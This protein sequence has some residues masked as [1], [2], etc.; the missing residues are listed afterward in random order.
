[1]FGSLHCTRIFNDAGSTC[2]L[3]TS[4]TMRR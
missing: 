1:M 3:Q 2:R 4:N